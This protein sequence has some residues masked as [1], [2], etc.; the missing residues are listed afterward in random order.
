MTT[1]A[2]QLTYLLLVAATAFAAGTRGILVR[3]PPIF[4]P[5]VAADVLVDVRVPITVTRDEVVGSRVVVLDRP[6]RRVRF[7]DG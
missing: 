7:E 2:L 1:T 3:R 6:V 5:A 4:V